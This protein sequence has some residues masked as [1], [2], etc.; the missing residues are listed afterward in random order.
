MPENN[1]DSYIYDKQYEPSTANI[2]APL[3]ILNNPLDTGYA[4]KTKHLT[5]AQSKTWNGA[6]ITNTGTEFRLWIEDAQMSFAMSGTNGQS[7]FRNQ[8]YPK[9]FNQPT[10]KVMG[11]MPNQYEYNKLAAFIRESHY[12]AL[13]QTNRDIGNIVASPTYDKKTIK[14]FIKD[15]GR[16]RQPKRN[17]KGGHTALAF[18]GYIKRIAAGA[19]RFE[20]APQFEFDFI[21]A[22]SVD[23]GQVGIYKDDL[24]QGT[25]I[26]SWM[27]LFNKYKFSWGAGQPGPPTKKE[28]PLKFNDPSGNLYEMI[29]A[30]GPSI[31]EEV[32]PTSEGDLPQSGGQR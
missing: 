17:L 4:V 12:D 25:Q 15:A 32:D 18:Q 14:L 30:T 5:A 19:T 24:T 22:S 6:L 9:A 8:F 3:E 7:R 20:F 29:P 2:G 10:L 13:N 11:R 31:M 27:E 23:T 26:M 21:I 1:E 28:G 16:G